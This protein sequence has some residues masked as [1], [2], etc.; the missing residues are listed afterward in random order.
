MASVAA[1][2]AL[3]PQLTLDGAALVA[4]A[5]GSRRQEVG[6]LLGRP[7]D[8]SAPGVLEGL[9]GLRPGLD[10]GSGMSPHMRGYNINERRAGLRG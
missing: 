7:R 4:L 1:W 9:T 8:V 5:G 3:D 6:P 2:A 10:S